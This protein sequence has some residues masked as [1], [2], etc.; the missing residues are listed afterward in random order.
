MK[1]EIHIYRTS[2]EDG[3]HCFYIG[4]TDPELLDEYYPSITAMP[5]WAK[6]K[7]S[8]LFMV[9]LVYPMERITGVGTRIDHQTYWI[10]VSEGELY[11]N[12]TRS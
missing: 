1:F 11:G 7:L 10:E 2:T 6:H 4:D 5:E 3:I 9:P 8:T 12:D